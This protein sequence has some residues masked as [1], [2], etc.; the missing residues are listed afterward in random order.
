M[1]DIYTIVPPAAPS[2]P[3]LVSVPHAGTAF[4]PELKAHF[5]A[6]LS[7]PPDDTDFFVEQLY[8]FVSA[9]GITMIYANY[10]RWVIDLNRSPENHSLYDDGRIITALTTTTDFLGNTIYTS[11][12]HEPDRR[13]IERRKELYFL[14]YY[15]QVT[16]LLQELKAK[17][18]QALL[19]DAHSIRRSVP[20]IRAMPFPDLILGDNDEHSADKNLIAIALKELGGGAFELQHNTPFKGGHITRHFGQPMRNIHALQLEMAK[21]LYMDDTERQYS[22]ERAAQIRPVLKRTFQ[23]LIDAMQNNVL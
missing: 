7:S 18:G 4:P 22:V 15:A 20:T 14:P 8:E 21:P 2:V 12:A 9:M 5:K 6:D 11:Q 1:S 3:I 10:S 13:E 19:W 23:A 17:F 16:K